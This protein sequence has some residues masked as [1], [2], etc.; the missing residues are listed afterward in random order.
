MILVTTTHALWCFDPARAVAYE[1]DC[2][3]GVYYG[4]GYSGDEIYVAARQAAYGAAM[5]TQDNVILRYGY[6]LRLRGMLRPPERLRD[7]HQI[8]W[9]DGKLW[10]CGTHNN[11]VF[12]WDGETWS[13]WTPPEFDVYR[14]LN[15]VCVC[16]EHVIL[17][18][19]RDQGELHFHRRSDLA[20][21]RTLTIGAKTHNVWRH[22]DRYWTFS[23]R[24]GEAV[25]DVGER[26]LIAGGA[27]VRGVSLTADRQFLGVCSRTTRQSRAFSNSYV[28][29]YDH[30]FRLLKKHAFPGHGMIHDIRVMGVLDAAHPID[31]PR[32][33]DATDFDRRFPQMR[34]TRGESFKDLRARLGAKFRNDFKAWRKAAETTAPGKA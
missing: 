26:H 8:A 32:A 11:Q 33:L 25:S 5:D 16:G 23:S 10:A 6:D 22:Q 21:V 20:Y 9:F 30:A 12:V 29:E 7:V 14:H 34:I 27:F 17:V 24:A 19:F 28:F 1:V 2:G 13:T 4:I 3:N 18:G 31:D 15:S